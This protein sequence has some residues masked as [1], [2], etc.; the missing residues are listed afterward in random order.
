VPNRPDVARAERAIRRWSRG[1]LDAATL[2]DRVLHEVRRAMPVDAAFFA[3]ADPESLLFTS[4]HAEDP[5]AA[6]SAAFV[7]NEFGA[8]DVNR[9]STLARARAHV[10]TL[11]TATRGDRAASARYREI[12]APLGLGDE[13]RLALVEGDRCWGYLCL[14]REDGPLGFTPAE[15]AVLARVGSH[16]AHGLRQAVLLHR[17]PADAGT[18]RPGVVLLDDAL[19]HVASTPE[20][21]QLLPL[22]PAD[23]PRRSPV[24]TAVR[25]VAAALLAAER[26]GPATGEP[27]P[28]S[29]RV[30]SAAGGWL[31]VHASRLGPPGAERIAVVVEAAGP[32]TT[33]GVLCAAHGLSPREHEVTRLVVHGM[34][35]REITAALH[36][37]AHTV[38]DHLKS[39]F[40]K[41]GVRSRRDLTVLLLSGTVRG[42]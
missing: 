42:H 30:P 35:T 23:R 29:A 2:R 3:T 40:D 41:V 39:V 25:A 14:H 5:L 6:V 7:A 22:L 1:G 8:G 11:D 36:I 24:P 18:P 27:P 37:S 4:V 12:M 32:A 21:E 28:P 13:L 33:F 38:Q 26:P 17:R 19:D 31:D 16:V 34:S 9:F 10:R 20:A 15:A